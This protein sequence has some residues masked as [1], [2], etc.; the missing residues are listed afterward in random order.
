V[1]CWGGDK[2]GEL[3]D[4][5]GRPRS[6][7]TVLVKGIE[8]ATAVALAAQ[9]ACALTSDGKVRC[10]GTGR[11]GNDGKPMANARPVE[12]AG[13]EGA[14]ELAASGAL[15]CA[16]MA[17]GVTC[18]GSDAHTIGAPPAG[19]FTQI[20][21]GFTHACALDKKGTVVCW[22]AGDWAAKGPYAKP[23]S[24]ASA[25]HLATGDR[26][27]CVVTKDK[28]VQCWG[29]NDAGQLGIKAD[30]ES[31]KSP[32]TVP[33]VAGAVKVFAGESSTCALLGDATVKCWGGNGAGELALGK[34]SSDERATKA[35]RLASVASLCIG[36]SH[37]CALT[38]AKSLLCWGANAEGQLGDGTTD[39]RLVPAPV[40]W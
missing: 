20:A 25:T 6:A 8:N 7:T 27:A 39:E 30:S 22:G 4:G 33:N 14:L 40:L 12:V 13:V 18:W 10:W 2:E 1:R 11:L 28:K 31:H 35:E 9:F 29:Q 34:R 26:H 23:A 17:T 24:I 15:A 37:G 38:T 16:R 5:G 19:V 21:T 32:V 3:G 36:S